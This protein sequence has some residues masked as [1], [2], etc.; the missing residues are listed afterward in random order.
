MERYDSYKDSGVKWLGEIPS[1]WEV[2]KL[3][4]LCKM[5]GRIGFRGYSRDDLVDDG[6]GAITLSPSNFSDG[7]LDFSNSS[8]LSWSKYYESPEIMVQNGDIVFVKTAS[9]GK[10]AYVE[11]LPVE[12]TVNPQIL[13]FKEIKCNAKFLSYYLQST[14]IQGWIVASANGS[15]IST[16]SQVSVGNYPV[17]LPA[18]KVQEALVEYIDIE[19]SKIDAAIAQQQKMIDLLNE[20]KQ[21]IINNAVTKGLDSNV[22]MKDSGIEWVGQVPKHWKLNRLKTFLSIKDKRNFDAMATLLS[23]YTAIG[24]KPRAELEEKGNKASTV[25]N[26]KIV[27]KGDLIV[28]RLLAWMG[29]YGIS[30]YDGVT[31]PDYDVYSFKEGYHKDFYGIMFRNTNFK[32]D[33]YKFGHGIMMMRWRTYPDEFLNILVPI[34]PYEEQK[35]I[36]DYLLPQIDKINEGIDKCNQIVSLL[37]ERKQI[38]INDVVT[39]KVKVV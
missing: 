28:N 5:F 35:Q 6:E 12:T 32:S 9:I 37:Q 11:N 7:H 8:Y 25:L 39:G 16:I 30:N 36:Y 20:R 24:V 10:V 38:I 15:T 14:K 1:H 27:N 22:S 31:S 26:Y 21:I 3:K 18:Q 2:V 13:V 34:P 23:V 33:C 4:S 19:I 17:I 29:A